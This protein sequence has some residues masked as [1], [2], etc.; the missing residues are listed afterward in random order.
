[1]YK[2]LI[3]IIVCCFNVFGM[4]GWVSLGVTVAG[5]VFNVYLHVISPLHRFILFS[6]LTQLCY[7]CTCI[8]SHNQVI[9]LNTRWICSC[10]LVWCSW[11]LDI[12]IG[13][14]NQLAEWVKKP[15]GPIGRKSHTADAQ[16]KQYRKCVIFYC[17]CQRTYI[18]LTNRLGFLL[19]RSVILP[20]KRHTASFIVL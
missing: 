6:T 10:F 4:D 18:H 9:Q 14:M 20:F 15:N 13:R 3:I 7:C 5:L 17:V 16:L 8:S 1:M 12:L 11:L 2:T 19:P